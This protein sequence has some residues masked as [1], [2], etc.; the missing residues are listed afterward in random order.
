MAF[1]Q[2]DSDIGA[3]R[4]QIRTVL[5]AAKTT[6]KDDFVEALA[7]VPPETRQNLREALDD[8]EGGGG[9]GKI[10]SLGNGLW[11]GMKD[12]GSKG[13][14]M[15]PGTEE[16][17]EEQGAKTAPVSVRMRWHSVGHCGETASHLYV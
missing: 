14:K 9:L 6:S 2:I 15:V 10:G 1:L 17:T 16:N 5:E 11:D 3:T 7:N 13:M 4:D 12:I 8:L